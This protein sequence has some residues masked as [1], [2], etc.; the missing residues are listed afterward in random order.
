MNPRD[1]A[2][3]LLIGAIWG[4]S[5]IFIRIIV[6]AVGPWSMVGV[7]MLISA[8][9]MYAALRV[10]GLRWGQS[11]LLW[12][13]VITA[14]FAS[15]AAQYLIASAALTLNAATLAILNT[16]A[17][18]FSALIMLLLYG[19]PLGWRRAAGLVLGM[20]GVAMV[21]GFAPLPLT[22][23][24][25]LA[26]AGALGAAACYAI[27]NVYTSRKLAQRP[28]LELS[29]AQSLFAGLMALPFAAP[30]AW[31]AAQAGAWTPRVVTA[32]VLLA[33]VC[34][35]FANGLFYALMKRTGPTASLSVT[36]L[37]PA[38]SLVWGWL[39]LDE[40]IAALQLAGFG[41]IVAALLMV[42]PQI[43]RPT[44]PQ[45]A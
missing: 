7:R 18:M 41:V 43:G 15:F 37:I 25:V 34:T 28:A 45:K 23:P 22:W 13:Y 12:H 36:Y 32:L 5:Y 44:A 24:V 39:F 2:T 20:L 10:A 9:V 21:V 27:A 8:A 40:T 3:L 19:E 29:F 17:A 16:T 1:F 6:P 33:V 30:A 14:F 42:A 26:F 38:F 4:A 11:K 31:N 35:A